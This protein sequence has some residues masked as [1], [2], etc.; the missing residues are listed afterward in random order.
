MKIEKVILSSDSNALYLDFWPIVP[1]DLCPVKI[2][3]LPTKGIRQIK[4]SLFAK[5]MKTGSCLFPA[6]A[7]KT[8]EE[9]TDR[10]GNTILPC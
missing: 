7:G 9:S 6:K 3:G 5:K 1:A 2:S 4:S 10:I 8:E